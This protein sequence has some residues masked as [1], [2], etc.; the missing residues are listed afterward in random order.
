MEIKVFNRGK[1]A[2]Y[3]VTLL[4]IGGCIYTE[5]L[6]KQ[7]GNIRASLIGIIAVYL[8]IQIPL[9]MLMA[10]LRKVRI[11]KKGCT[12]FYPCYKKFVGWEELEQKSAVMNENRIH[13]LLLGIYPNEYGNVM[14]DFHQFTYWYIA[15]GDYDFKHYKVD[16]DYLGEL[17][18]RRSELLEVLERNQIELKKM[19]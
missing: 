10:M 16:E 6:Q 13:T 9:T 19:K 18:A 4:G 17:A 3:I 14:R 11:E 2:G 5:I 7:E 15:V 12:F 8:F 1:T